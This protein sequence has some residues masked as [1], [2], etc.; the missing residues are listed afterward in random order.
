MDSS[1]R[2]QGALHQCV[3]SLSWHGTYFRCAQSAAK[4]LFEVVFNSQSSPHPGVSSINHLQG[5]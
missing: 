5:S 3:T 4:S 2:G 1:N